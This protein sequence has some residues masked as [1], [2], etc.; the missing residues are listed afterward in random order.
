MQQRLLE[1]LARIRANPAGRDFLLADAKDPDMALG[2]QSLGRVYPPLT[3]QGV[4][5][6][7][8]GEFHEQ[9]RRVV[10]Q[11]VV[12][13]M[14][15]SVAT[16]SVLGHRERLFDSSDVTPAVRINDTTDI[17]CVRGGIYRQL[18]SLPFASAYLE[19]AQFGTLTPAAE[20][21]PRVNLGLYSITLNNDLRADRETLVALKEFRAE[22]QRHGFH[23]FLEVFAPNTAAGLSLEQV[24]AFVNDH[25]ARLLAGVPAEGRPL[26]L[27]LPYFGPQW[28]EEL[29]TYDPTQV[30]GVLGG[31]SGTTYDAFKLLAEAQRYGARAAIFGRKIKDA[32]EPLAFIA[33]LRRIVD[34]ELSPEEAVRAY[35]GELQKQGIPPH[36]C[37][38]DDMRLT[39]P[40]LQYIA[41][42]RA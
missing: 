4:V 22:A 6:R 31:G 35:H 26:F 3:G 19:E 25:I 10:Q 42:K 36:R 34:G 37:L 32:E 12:D 7:T 2:T 16:M 17:W 40:E 29:V 11:G 5:Y 15:T 30:I 28:M 39:M 18:P 24:P 13:L 33:M 21:R 9:I 20:A 14:L 23:Y 41:K 38:E 27:K 8:T 1:K